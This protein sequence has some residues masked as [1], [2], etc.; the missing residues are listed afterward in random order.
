MHADFGNGKKAT[1]YDKVLILFFLLLS[2]ALFLLVLEKV[3]R[4]WVSDILLWGLLGL[5]LLAVYLFPTWIF[6]RNVRLRGFLKYFFSITIVPFFL[7]LMCANIVMTHRFFPR[8]FDW[9]E[10]LGPP[11]LFRK[12]EDFFYM[13]VVFLISCSIS[14]PLCIGW[15][16]LLRSL[17]RRLQRR[18]EAKMPGPILRS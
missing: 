15:Y 17:D 16:M 11:H 2:L 4:G 7:C 18:G 12:P 5:I 1:L 9:Y 8:L 10:K 13:P 14:I 6:I 3:K